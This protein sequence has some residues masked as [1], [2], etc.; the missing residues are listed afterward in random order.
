MDD[1]DNDLDND[2]EFEHPAAPVAYNKTI[3][4]NVGDNT[5]HKR[6][7]QHFAVVQ[8]YNVLAAYKTSFKDRLAEAYDATYLP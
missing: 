7:A 8:D 6:E 3:A 5:C 4:A 2:W 1:E